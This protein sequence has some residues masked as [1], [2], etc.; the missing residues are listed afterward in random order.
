[1]STNSTP[2]QHPEPPPRVFIGSSTEALDLAH[3]IGEGLGGG[4]E[5]E[6]KVWDQNVLQPGE[7]L[8]E[9]LLRLVNLFDFVILLLSADDIIESRKERESVPRDNVV[10]EL[11]MFMGALGRR[12]A[13]PIILED[14]ESPL[15]LPTDLAGLIYSRLDIDKI[16]N[17]TYFTEKVAGIREQI[18]QRSK[19]AP[20]SLLP[21]IGLAFGYLNNFLIPVKERMSALTS[22]KHYSKEELEEVKSIKFIDEIRDGNFTFWI[23]YPRLAFKASIDNRAERVRELGLESVSVK[24]KERSYPFF[25]YPERDDNGHVR[26]ADYPTTLRSSSDAIDLVLKEGELGEFEEEREQ[27]ERKEVINF[28]KALTYLLKRN[29]TVGE[30]FRERIRF[31]QV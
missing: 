18:K 2:V 27:L 20:L 23:L 13:L 14:P 1:V 30:S 15:K 24:Y 21:S 17:S 10:F 7:M 12:R 29:R 5:L 22:T 28:I 11:G 26:F 25:V 9:G 19:S 16:N 31:Q 4:K 6:V 3:R 8:L